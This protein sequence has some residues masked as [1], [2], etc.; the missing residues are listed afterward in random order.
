MPA[1]PAGGADVHAL[2]PVDVALRD[3]AGPLPVP[4]QDRLVQIIEQTETAADFDE[5][6]AELTAA[7]G[8]RSRGQDLQRRTF[9]VVPP[10]AGLAGQGRLLAEL[11]HD[12]GER[13]NAG[14]VARLDLAQDLPPAIQNTLAGPLPAIPRPVDHATPPR[15]SD[16]TRRHCDVRAI[17]A[18]G[19]SHRR[20]PHGRGRKRK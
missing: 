9:R 12:V 20:R 5:A 6:A 16:S 11:V 18:D 14:L 15:E 4:P 8:R 17:P 13:Q 3:E 7:A 1:G 10:G 19:T 2:E